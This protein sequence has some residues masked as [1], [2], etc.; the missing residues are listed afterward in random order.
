MDELNK[1]E[2]IKIH[3]DYNILSACKTKIDDFDELPKW[4]Q[5]QIKSLLNFIN[6]LHVLIND[7]FID[8][9]LQLT[10]TLSSM[11]M[12]CAF[13]I[14][15]GISLGHIAASAILSIYVGGEVTIIFTAFRKR[16]PERRPGRDV[17]R[18][19]RWPESVV[20]TGSGHLCCPCDPFLRLEPR[21]LT[22]VRGGRRL[23]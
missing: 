6:T 9:L 1:L 8:T 2:N 5:I 3:Y 17:G 19:G 23:G 15:F 12:Y 21:L 4:F 7:L 18:Q 22:I 14:I 11:S 20:R 13:A 16:R 10:I